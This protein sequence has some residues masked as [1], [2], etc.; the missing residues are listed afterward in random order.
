MSLMS[1]EVEPEEGNFSFWV[2]VAFTCNFIVGTVR[3][4]TPC[5]DN[6]GNVKQSYAFLGLFSPPT[7][8]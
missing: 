2:A 8:L 1:G 4:A 7:L 3:A 6:T 5:V